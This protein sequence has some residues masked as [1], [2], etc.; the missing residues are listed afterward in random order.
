MSSMFVS[1]VPLQFF[2]VILIC[3]SKITEKTHNAYFFA[4]TAAT[5]AKIAGFV[6]FPPN[7]PTTRFVWHMV[8]LDWTSKAEATNTYKSELLGFYTG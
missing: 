2:L 8:L 3:F 1:E 4:A 7:A 6:I 5:T